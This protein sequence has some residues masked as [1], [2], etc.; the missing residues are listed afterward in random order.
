MNQISEASP[1][2][3]IE[4]S[5]FET[6]VPRQRVVL[7]GAS[8]LTIMFPTIVETLRATLAAPIDLHVAKGFGR[9]YGLHSQFFGKKFPGILS[10]GLWPA[11]NRARPLPTVAVI[12]DVGNDLAYEAP[13]DKVVEWVERAL[14][15]LASHDARAVINNVP[16]ESLRRVGAARY[17]GLREVLFPSC[18]LSRIEMLRRAESLCERLVELGESRKTPVFSGEAA[19]Y[20]WDPIH[21]KLTFAG[22]IW[23]RM[24]GVLAG[25]DE[26]VAL[27]RPSSARALHYRRLRPL[28]CAQFG[29]VRRAEQPAL[30]E[31]DG[32]TISIY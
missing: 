30:R 22:E 6:C 15:R 23:R 21:P 13:V 17:Y 26:P 20:G 27:V 25:V 28:E 5:Q 18:K 7:L 14:D 16:I 24:L 12:A 31:R 11:M 8:N 1:S 4:S 2:A 10:S 19:W 3:A 32:S 9:S 29:V